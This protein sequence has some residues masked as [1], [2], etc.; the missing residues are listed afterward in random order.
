MKVSPDFP[1]SNLKKLKKQ[2]T[3]S[4]R[5]YREAMPVQSFVSHGIVVRDCLDF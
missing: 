2:R 5:K 3:G 4:H 1:I